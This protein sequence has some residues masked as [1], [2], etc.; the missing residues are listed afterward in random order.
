MCLGSIACFVAVGESPRGRTSLQFC[1]AVETCSDHWDKL[2]DPKIFFYMFPGQMDVFNWFNNLGLSSP[3]RSEATHNKLEI[4]S[5]ATDLLLLETPKSTS[6]FWS[7][8][9]WI[10]CE[11]EYSS[12]IESNVPI[13]R[14]WVVITPLSGSNRLGPVPHSRVEA[15]WGTSMWGVWESTTRTSLWTWF[16]QVFNG[17]LNRL[18]RVH[19]LPFLQHLAHPIPS[20]TAVNHL[21][22]LPRINHI[23][24]ML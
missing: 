8:F 13:W 7:I 11:R 4:R 23:T 1:L 21:Q 22:E 15:I 2:L 19:L 14:M 9:C 6:I 5:S 17:S 20:S 24:F 16:G 18:G 3:A 12:T 10:F